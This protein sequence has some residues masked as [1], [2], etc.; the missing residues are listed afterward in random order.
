MGYEKTATEVTCTYVAVAEKLRR[1]IGFLPRLTLTL[2][3][4]GKSHKINKVRRRVKLPLNWQHGCIEVLRS[5]GVKI[6]DV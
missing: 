2:P 4:D 3:G 5:L 6:K 1:K